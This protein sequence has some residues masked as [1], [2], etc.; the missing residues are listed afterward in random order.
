MTTDEPDIQPPDPAAPNPAARITA[1]QRFADSIMQRLDLLDERL[2]AM[3]SDNGT[4]EVTTDAGTVELQ[5]IGHALDQQTAAIGCI[6]NAVAD[7]RNNLPVSQ[8]QAVSSSAS[9]EPPH[10][11][12]EVSDESQ[13]PAV[14]DAWSQIRNAFLTDEAESAATVEEDQPP[15]ED[16]PGAEVVQA[17]SAIV[18]TSKAE[19]VSSVESSLT[20]EQ[21]E[22]PAEQIPVAVD[23]SKLSAEQLVAAVYERDEFIILLM[24]RLQTRLQ[25]SQP[26][27]TEQLGELAST[28]PE[29]L[30]GRAVST[31][32]LLETQVRLGELELSLERAQL[33][34]KKSRLQT[35]HE[36]LAA[37]AR[38]LGLTLNDDGTVDGEVNVTAKGSRGRQ[39]LGAMGFGN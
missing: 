15:G 8:A 39:W 33:A 3:A 21:C 32:K 26:I 12:D 6:A 29:D 38:V 13:P 35:A 19:A 14:A 30:Q 1:A 9:D 34:R 18:G 28:L 20:V 10:V 25:R 16:T 23:P 31:L 27:T 24:H 22:I 36:K 5:R 37:S 2:V 17:E 7:L 4:V 11:P